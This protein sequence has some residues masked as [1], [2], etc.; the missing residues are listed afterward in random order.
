MTKFVFSPD[1]HVGWQQTSKGLQP[2]HDQKA[3][4]SVLKFASDFLPD[5]WI[6][7]G[8]NMDY[9]P[10]SH[11]LKH[12]KKSSK[13]LDLSRDAHEYKINV[14]D[15][16][17]EIMGRRSREKKRKIWMK[18]NHEGWAGEFAEENPGVAGLVEPERLLNLKGWEMLDEGETVNLG[19]LYFAHGDKIGNVRNVA[20]AAVQ[21][22]GHPIVFGHFH[23]FQV[24]PRHELIG[25][26][27]VKMGMCVPGLCNKNP[28]YMG[29]RP[30]Q[31][32]KGF[33]YGYVHEDGTFQIY[34]PLIIGGKFAAEGKVYRG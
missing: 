13:D 16:I 4:D 9:G 7:G 8:D 15:P 25:S 12:K 32:M 34:V 10:V 3:I 22:Y 19:K 33:A 29:N 30:N 26:D 6:E 23:T 5:V 24:A 21:L 28:S 11:W 14:L 17:N 18:G 2:L 20:A 1:K 27:S 31:W